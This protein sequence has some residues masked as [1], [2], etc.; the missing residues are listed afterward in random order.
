PALGHVRVAKITAGMIDRTIDACGPEHSDSTIRNSIAP[1][2]RVLDEAVR[3]DI[4]AI[5]RPSVEQTKGRSSTLSTPSS[6]AL[7]PTRRTP[8]R[9]Y[10]DLAEASSPT[11]PSGMPPAGMTSSQ[12]S[13]TFRNDNALM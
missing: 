8:T 7:P 12:P 11:R 4:S 9:S 3:D 5:R 13:T 6:N 10:A 2:V 1:H